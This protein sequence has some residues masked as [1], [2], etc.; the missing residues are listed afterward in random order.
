MSLFFDIFIAVFLYTHYR[1]NIPDFTIA[2]KE[3][4]DKIDGSELST[5]DII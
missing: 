5:K 4:I 3:W 2:D 1:S